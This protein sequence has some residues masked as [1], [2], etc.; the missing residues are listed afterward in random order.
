MYL[1]GRPIGSA[2]T[3]TDEDLRS[4]AITTQALAFVEARFDQ[5]SGWVSEFEQ[6]QQLE[7]VR[8]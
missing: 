1:L 4:I 5:I 3:M 7:A 8:F 6:I 2:Q